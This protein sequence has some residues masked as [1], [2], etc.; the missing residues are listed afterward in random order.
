MLTAGTNNYLSLLLVFNL[1][2]PQILITP[3]LTPLTLTLTLTP[4]INNSH[5][6]RKM[7]SSSESKPCVTAWRTCK[8][9]RWR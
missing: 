8:R 7:L 6:P 5:E 9:L 2:E 3:L 1:L 4:P